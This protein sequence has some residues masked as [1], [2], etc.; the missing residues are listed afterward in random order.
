MAN[1]ED[2]LI[3]R[4]DVPFETD[5]F[6]DVD[7]LVFSELIYVNFDGIV[8]SPGQNKKISIED[9]ADLFFSKY[10]K[11]QLM[12]SKA[13]T[14]LAPFLMPKMAGSK[15]FGGTKIYGYVNE[16]DH[17]NQSQFAA[18]CFLLPDN[19]IFVAFRG[20]D[21]N[22]VG[23]KE[24]FN[25]CFSEGTGGQLKACEYLNKNLVR[26]MRPIRVGGHS[27]GG[28]FAEYSSAFCRPHIRDNIIQIYNYDG[29]GFIQEI[30]DSPQ[31]M[32]ILSRIK[33]FIPKESMIGLLMHTKTSVSI[34]KSSQKG[35]YQ[36]DLLSWQIICNKF[37]E[38]EKLA[39]NA[40]FIDEIIKKW[41]VEFDYETRAIFGDIFF[42]NL[43]NSSGASN[44]SEITSN[45]IKSAAYF[46]KELQ[47]LPQEKQ[48]LVVSV[49]LKLLA[50]GGDSVK[51]SLLSRLPKSVK[52]R[53]KEKKRDNE[54]V[55]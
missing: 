23:W 29:P 38:E 26:T 45:K 17:D 2:Y 5:P 19:T 25:M 48:E 20:T 51:N 52:V 6:N 3:W 32:A 50:V 4:G 28:N 10:S 39:E 46:T 27:K 55:I 24:D 41:S 36:H 16:I 9:A 13:M 8:P 18:C 21:D 43:K 53:N 22:L 30:I 12:S 34:V 49:L 33:K 42:E 44:L 47:N 14:K 15:R 35:I 37:E 1:I 11:G 7:A 31:Y 40:I 54:S